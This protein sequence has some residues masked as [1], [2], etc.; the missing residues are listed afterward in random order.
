M[1]AKEIN[2]RILMFVDLIRPTWMSFVICFTISVLTV[3]FYYIFKSIKSVQSSQNTYIVN[4][5]QL[6]FNKFLTKLSNYSIVNNLVPILFWAFVG[7]LVYIFVRLM[8][9]DVDEF[10]YDLSKRKRFLWP[11]GA[12]PHIIIDFFERVVIRFVVF[13]FLVIYFVH[14]VSPFF[15]GGVV[16]PDLFGDTLKKNISNHI[17]LSVPLFIILETIALFGIVVI[18][19]LFLLKRRLLSNRG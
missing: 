13:I 19:R 1:R 18:L 3:L 11:N 4:Y 5:V 8:V 16:V 7:I 17:F 9:G 2:K 12:K 10:W 6:D 14:V 15:L